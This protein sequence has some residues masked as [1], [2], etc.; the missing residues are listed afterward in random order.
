MTRTE[1]EVSEVESKI[2]IIRGEKVL[3]GPDL[4][5]LYGVTTKR[6]N[7]QVKRNLKRFPADFMFILSEQEFRNLRSQIATSSS[8]W[9]GHRVPPFAFTEQGVAMLSSVLN[10]DCA[11]EVNIIV[12]RAFVRLRKAL[13]LDKEFENRIAQLERKYDGQFK[14][15]FDAIRELMSNHPVPR[16]RIIGLGDMDG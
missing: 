8:S 6:L 15:V 11:I 1:I 2:Y 10:S 13:N 5:K 12:M 9:G 7:E 3:L 4:A 14:I 16:K